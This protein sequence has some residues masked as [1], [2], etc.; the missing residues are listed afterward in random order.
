MRLAWFRLPPDVDPALGDEVTLPVLGE[1]PVTGEGDVDLEWPVNQD[2]LIT[3]EHVFA[4]LF[5]RDVGELVVG[6]GKA[7]WDSSKFWAQP[8]VQSLGPTILSLA[9]IPGPFLLFLCLSGG[10]ALLVSQFS[11]HFLL[12]ATTIWRQNESDTG[13]ADVVVVGCSR[14]PMCRYSIDDFWGLQKLKA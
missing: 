11:D 4:K 5:A 10:S 3:R 12:K 8:T 9:Y 1:D 13:K 2:G 7:G 6:L 14:R